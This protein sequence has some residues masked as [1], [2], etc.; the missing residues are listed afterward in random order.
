[1]AREEQIS[2]SLVRSQT[3]N[4]VLQQMR[5]DAAALQQAFGSIRI[6]QATQQMNAQ[7]QAATAAARA[8]QAN[9][10]AQAAQARATAATVNIQTAQARA[11]QA[12]ANAQ[13]AQNRAAQSAIGVLTAQANA[14]NAAARAQAAQTNAQ[15]ANVRLQTQQANAAAANLRVQQQ[16]VNLMTAQVRLQNAVNAGA[17][18]QQR[19]LQRLGQQIGQVNAQ[20]AQAVQFMTQWIRQQQDMGNAQVTATG[21]IHNAAGSF[22]T[23]RAAVQEAGGAMHNFRFAV[24]TANGEVYQLDQGVRTSLMSLRDLSVVMRAVRTVVGFT[25]IA[26]S[27]RSAL[28]EMKSMSDEMVV[29]RKVTGATADEMDR[30]RQS[31]YDIAKKYGQ[32][33]SD[34]LSAASEMARA[35]YGQN[36]VA[37][38]ELATKTQL[39]GDMTAEMASKFL[40]AVDAGYK[41]KGSVQDLSNVLDAANEIDNNYATSIAKISEGMTLIASLGGQAGVPIEELIAALG[42][43]TAA[44]Q[45]SGAEMARGL[46]SIFLNVLKD[47]STEIEDG[48]K[49]T[50]ENIESLTDALILYGDESIKAA[51]KAGKLINPMKAIGALAK[52]YRAGLFTEQ[53]LFTMSRNIAGQRYYNAFAALIENYD[54]MYQS[55][56]ATAQNATGSAEREVNAMLDSWTVKFNQLKTTWAEVVNNS[57]SEGFIKNLLSSGQQV[58]E[59]AGNLE[60]LAVMAGGALVA[61]RSLSA[62]LANLSTGQQ[63]GMFNI[64]ASLAGIA[65][66]GIGIL[67]S[68]YESNIRQ[69]QQDA[70]EAVAKAVE[71]ST[72]LKSLYDIEKKYADIAGDGIQTEKGELD[73]L[74]SLQTDL[75]RLVG[76]QASA[77]DLVNGKYGETIT[78]LRKMTEEQRKA[79]IETTRASLSRAVAA[80]KTS[81]LNGDFNFG[82]YTGITLPGNIGGA[83]FDFIENM[84]YFFVKMNDTVDRF[85]D[86][87]LFLT[88]KPDNAEDII[89]FYKE[90]QDFYT[91]LGT[92]SAGDGAETLGEK[93][94]RFYTDLGTFL[95]TVKT[96]ADPVQT[97][98]DGLEELQKGFEDLSET[99]SAGDAAEG[100]N[101]VT[102]SVTTLAGAIDAATAAKEKFDEAM[103][104]TKADAFNTYTGAFQTLQ[105]EI[106][107]GRVNSTAFYAA[108]RMILGDEAYR[109]TGGTSEGVMAA[110]SRRGRSGSVWDAW[111]I[112][113]AEYKDEAG[114]AAEGYGIYELLKR[115]QG[116]GGRLTDSSGNPF[117]PELTE[118]DLNMISEQWGDISKDYI[119]AALN[120]LDQYDKTG[121]ATEEAVKVNEEQAKQTVQANENAVMAAK[122]QETLAQAE[123]QA[124]EATAQAV[125]TLTEAAENVQEAVTGE[126]EEGETAQQKAEKLYGILEDIE[127]LYNRINSMTVNPEGMDDINQLIADI[128]SLQETIT[129]NIKNGTG[130]GNAALTCA[131]IANQIKTIESYATKGKIDVTVAAQMTGDLK[132]SL[133]D[134]ISNVETLD[135]LNAIQLVLTADGSQLDADIQAAITKK[136]EEI[137][138]G[139]KASSGDLTTVDNDIN[140]VASKSRTAIIN[141]RAKLEGAEQEVEEYLRSLGIGGETG[142]SGGSSGVTGGTGPDPLHSILDVYGGKKHASGTNWHPGGAALVN[143]GS[144]PELISDHGVAFIANGGKPS[145]VSLS[146]GARVFNATQTRNIFARSG[147]PA[148]AAG[149]G[150]L[151]GSDVMTYVGGMGGYRPSQVAS[152]VETQ[153]ITGFGTRTRTTTDQAQSSSASGSGGGSSKKSDSKTFETLKDMVDYILKHISEA[154]A[155][156]LKALDAEKEQ[157]K[158][159]REL[160]EQ[161]NELEERQKAVAEA[162]K[163]LLDAMSER[164]VR[165][166][167]EDG[168]WHWASDARQVQK[169]QESLDKAKKD[170]QEYEEKQDYERRIKEIDD[171]KKALQDEYEEASD[172][173]E[174]IQSGISTPTGDLTEALTAVLTGGTDQQKTGATALRDV[175][176]AYLTGGTFSGSYQ[177]ALEAIRLA[178][179]GTPVMPDASSI[180]GLI[181]TGGGLTGTAANAMMNAGL[182]NPA[183]IT[184]W[185][186]TGTS[187]SYNYYVDGMQIGAVDAETRS[188]SDIMRSLSV[189]AG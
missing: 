124:A 170:L 56:L 166:I 51:N 96:A 129:I 40:L 47:T 171:Q 36:S 164:T 70:A 116:F 54:D 172:I 140:K 7:A 156:Q 107:A 85:G 100:I 12:Q 31:S 73:E 141:V 18:N 87:Q 173:W 99:Q 109:S 97:A 152:V 89:A 44:T 90:L 88:R 163:D 74:K 33:P 39:V 102:E 66:A 23:Y 80:F 176:L 119:V 114:N 127:S 11:A 32:T 182:G 92:T 104:T 68:A 94:S 150:F 14:A 69:M 130:N 86:M 67:K 57:V 136:R 187:I 169:A 79:V 128:Q 21:A 49:V 139:V 65:I 77:I 178:T 34:F 9:A 71:K 121:A 64:G 131:V 78:A 189:Y 20:Q 76:D 180:A 133:T 117:I 149:T 61:I 98:Y 147:L 105:G 162:Q 43:M 148:Y 48:V 143:D 53:E 81:D 160:A 24:N 138:L 183:M 37:M 59:F 153:S 135:E 177:S 30:I 158:Q 22:Q 25:G 75:N 112:L 50:E 27:M 26:Q 63:F 106:D 122:G 4:T 83:V 58:L 154:L 5:A 103:K 118:T 111:D 15:T 168:K 108:A 134:V 91:F 181:A 29:Y 165:Y 142:T 55:M 157:I 1:M 186:N 155:A 46:R 13:N 144:G 38:A 151:K 137:V 132:Q 101:T 146:K 10:N 159:E 45:R 84:D 72:G 179:A 174:K 60:N 120:A 16:Q 41:Y 115:T 82:N 126:G 167:G 62:G 8:A 42:T 28:S 19:A 2:V 52:A 110:L 161:Q 123:Q 113:S 6:A 95:A 93:F 175:L 3:Y 184:P 125:E 145:I 185:G 17:N 35:G 188:L